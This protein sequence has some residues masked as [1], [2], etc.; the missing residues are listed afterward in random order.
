MTNSLNVKVCLRTN[1]V[2]S[3]RVEISMFHNVCH[4]TIAQ[5]MIICIWKVIERNS[6]MKVTN[7]VGHQNFPLLS[8]GYFSKNK[9]LDDDRSVDC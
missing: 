6:L 4:F 2:P 5:A 8:R 9:I 1:H 3:P 7:I